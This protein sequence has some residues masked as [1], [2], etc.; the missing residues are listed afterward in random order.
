MSPMT[1]RK[2]CPIKTD[3]EVTEMIALGD[4]YYE[5]VK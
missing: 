1:R 2:K 4:S 3:T 5:H